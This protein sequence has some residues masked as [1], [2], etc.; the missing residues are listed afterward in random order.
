ML[1]SGRE[2]MV[3]ADAQITVSRALEGR[4][5]SLYGISSSL[6]RLSYS[7]LL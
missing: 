4:G 1:L 2:F 7:L 5:F 6:G 3:S